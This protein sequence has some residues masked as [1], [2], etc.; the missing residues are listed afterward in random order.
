MLLVDQV[1]HDP[2]VLPYH[3]RVEVTDSWFKLEGNRIRAIR[4]F[5]RI[6]RRIS[7]PPLA[8]E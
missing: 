2:G 5:W 4:G 6:G 7:Q 8:L 3:F 1:M